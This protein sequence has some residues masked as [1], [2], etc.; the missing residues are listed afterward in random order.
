VERV[1][2]AVVA[3][4]PGADRVRAREGVSAH[5]RSPRRWAQVPA[6][7]RA[8]LSPLGTARAAASLR[9]LLLLHPLLLLPLLL[10]LL[11]L[12]IASCGPIRLRH[13]PHH[14]GGRIL[15]CLPTRAHLGK[16]SSS[17]SFSNT[18]RS[19]T[20]RSTS[21][22]LLAARVPQGV[23]CALVCWN[24]AT[25]HTERWRSASKESLP[26]LPTW[27]HPPPRIRPLAYLVRVMSSIT[28]TS[29]SH[30]TATLKCA[31]SL[32]SGRPCSVS[33]TP[34]SSAK[35][36]AV[37]FHPVRRW[38]VQRF[39]FLILAVLKT[40]LRL[41]AICLSPTL[42]SPTLTQLFFVNLSSLFLSLLLLLLLHL[43]LT[44][45]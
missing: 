28:A 19:S 10:S 21:S 31:T 22:P 26:L 14:R 44:S 33:W 13:R 29:V 5:L 16:H 38:C 15:M 11:L 35:A 2:A 24:W 39:R 40:P 3:M 36:N 4:V 23:A 6:N 12:T 41:L 42:L 8:I 17:N 32:P 34:I 25:R 27:P 7:T 43:P 20:N 9:R 37:G 45:L 18:I 1:E 30:R